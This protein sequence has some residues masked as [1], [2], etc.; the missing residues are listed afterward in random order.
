M[1]L[2][3][4]D[5]GSFVGVLDEVPGNF[6]RYWLLLI[7]LSAAALA[8]SDYRSDLLFWRGDSFFGVAVGV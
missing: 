1:C 4:V 5:C 6:S 2:G 3:C 8:L 7:S